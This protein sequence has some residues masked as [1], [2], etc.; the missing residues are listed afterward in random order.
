MIESA[1]DTEL[2]GFSESDEDDQVES[3]EIYLAY[4]V[5]SLWDEGVK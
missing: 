1:S 2:S 3:P 4:E 5:K